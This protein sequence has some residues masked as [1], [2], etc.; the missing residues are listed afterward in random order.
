MMAIGVSKT[1][2]SGAFLLRRT[3][4]LAM[5]LQRTACLGVL[6]LRCLHPRSWRVT[7]TW[8]IG[9]ARSRWGRRNAYRCHP[10][11]LRTRTTAFPADTRKP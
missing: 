4:S 8:S 2:K 1:H 7:E 6:N 9:S 10:A 5:P 11:A 3:S